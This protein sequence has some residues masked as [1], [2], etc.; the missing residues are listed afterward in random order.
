MTTKAI[1]PSEIAGQQLVK[2]DQ[3]F[4]NIV[5]KINQKLVDS[6]GNTQFTFNADTDPQLVD[7][8]RDTYAEQ[9]WSSLVTQSEHGN[10]VLSVSRVNELE[11]PKT[12]ED[13]LKYFNE[14]Y[15]WA[16]VSVM[17]ENNHGY[18][19]HITG[20]PVHGV[21]G[22]DQTCERV[23]V[24]VSVMGNDFDS[25]AKKA[26]SA[27]E[28]CNSWICSPLEIEAHMNHAF[29]SGIKAMAEA[30]GTFDEFMPLRSSKFTSKFMPM[31]GNMLSDDT[32]LFG[33]IRR[34]MPRT[35]INRR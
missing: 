10:Y 7:K 23:S 3:T 15:P 20:S 32:E 14:K 6:H 17:H 24:D 34:L 18:S 26:I 35:L 4:D 29:D 9:G 31:I 12:S 16:K 1:A 21:D 33:K 30:F 27:V 8:V 11:V 22:V 2:R 19:I 13:L 28:R 25:I 5:Q